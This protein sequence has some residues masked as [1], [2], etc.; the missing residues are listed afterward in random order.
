M[1]KLVSVLV[2]VSIACSAYAWTDAS[3][4]YYQAF[5]AYDALK[6]VDTNLSKNID[7]ASQHKSELAFKKAKGSAMDG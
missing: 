5:A 2:W 4:N 7:K 3:I 6:K 1:K